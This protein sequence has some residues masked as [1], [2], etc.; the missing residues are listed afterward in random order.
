MTATSGLLHT[1]DRTVGVKVDMDEAVK[2][3]TPSDVPLQQ[4]LGTD[5]TNEIKVEWME[6]ELLPQTVTLTSKSGAGPWVGVCASTAE[7]RVGDILAV[8]NGTNSAL[9]WY[10]SAINVNGTDFTL[11]GHAGNSTSPGAT[12]TL[13]IV[14]QYLA[15]GADPLDMRSVERTA[16]YNYTQ[17]VQEKVQATRT[18]RHRGARGGMY[19]EGDPYDKELEKKFKELAIR[20]ERQLVHGQRSQSGN[21]RTMGGLFYYITTNNTSGVQANARTLVNTAIRAA[22]DNG[23]SGKYALVVSPT[24]KSILSDLDSTQRRVV[25]SG[26]SQTREMGYVVDRFESDFGEVDIIPNRHFPRTRGLCLQVEDTQIVNF[27]PYVHEMLAKT[28][29]ADNGQIVG[30]KTLRVK[31]EKASGLFTITDA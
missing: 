21:Y 31:N 29:D 6:E 1:S 11:T 3:L 27:D 8:R 13:E 28:G 19:G 12:D 23:G 25:S 4:L 17:V 18:A 26:G 10:V 9:Q 22:Y 20:F 2:I 5:S 15:E 24:V 30:E 16:K 7:L 14:G